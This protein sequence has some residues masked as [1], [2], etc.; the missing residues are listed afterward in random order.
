MLGFQD[1][2]RERC[3][4]WAPGGAILATVD[5]VGVVRLWNLRGR[6]K[7]GQG[8][9]QRPEL[10][11]PQFFLFPQLDAR[12]PSGDAAKPAFV[13]W[14][15]RTPCAVAYG[16]SDDIV[17]VPRGAA[18]A[19]S[20]RRRRQRSSIKA[21]E[22]AGA[23][24]CDL[25]ARRRFAYR[26]RPAARRRRSAVSARAA[27]PRPPPSRGFASRLR[28]ARRA[29]GG[30][31]A[32]VGTHT[33]REGERAGLDLRRVDA[34][35]GGGAWAPRNK[36]SAA[37]ASSAST[38]SPP[39]AVVTVT[40][41]PHCSTTL[42]SVSTTVSRVAGASSRTTGSGAGGGRIDRRA[43]RSASFCFLAFSAPWAG[44]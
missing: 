9:P 4:A 10:M 27:A 22:A 25:A 16:G 23:Q 35:F 7:R 39:S 30:L 34:F 6:L 28:A 42:L 32:E 40:A 29:F 2:S 31:R 19:P 37:S 12:A 14:L 33:A 38:S 5:A 13:G 44:R 36:A 8:H 20:P 11:K 18:A 43:A 1:G 26:Y 41:A 3:V 15:S 17:R 24:K 21:T